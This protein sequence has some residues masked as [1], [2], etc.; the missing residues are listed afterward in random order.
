[1]KSFGKGGLALFLVALTACGGEGTNQTGAIQVSSGSGSISGTT[2][3]PSPAASPAAYTKISDLSASQALDAACLIPW[4]TNVDL[5]AF[6]TAAIK[7]DR[8]GGDASY[9]VTDFGSRSFVLADRIKATSEEL[10]YKQVS[11]GRTDYL[12][13]ASGDGPA[14][15]LYSRSADLTYTGSA[16]GT[17]WAMCVAG[18]ATRL[19][20]VPKSSSTFATLNVYAQATLQNNATA[21]YYTITSTPGSLTIDPVAKKI[22]AQ[23]TFYGRL[24]ATSTIVEL[25]R[26][27]FT[28]EYDGSGNSFGGDLVDRNGPT[29]QASGAFFGPEGREVAIAFGITRTEANGRRSLFY[30]QIIGTR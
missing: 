20:D 5:T 19:S 11:S 25:G 4:L 27:L 14:I 10:R 18:S 21:E 28:T 16:T 12:T 24:S 3:T 26:F 6:Q 29:A 7:F 23:L 15:P 1:M 22:T 2:P 30:G 13:L 17:R 9:N 8:D